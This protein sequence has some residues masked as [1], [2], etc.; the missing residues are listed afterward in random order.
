MTP[1]PREIRSYLT[2]ES[3]HRLLVAALSELGAELEDVRAHLVYQISH[4]SVT[5]QAR[6]DGKPGY[7]VATTRPLPEHT[8]T[9]G[10]EQAAQR[11][12][13]VE[14]DIGPVTVFVYPHDPFL[15]ALASLQAEVPTPADVLAYRPT[16]R[17]VLDLG[18]RGFAKIAAPR[19]TAQL[20]RRHKQLSAA[21][22]PVPRV[23]E[24]HP[25]AVIISRLQGARLTAMVQEEG[26]ASTYAHVKALLDSLPAAV[27]R[28]PARRSWCER[29]E[30]H[31][32]SARTV[33][34]GH[35]QRIERIAAAV[36]EDLDAGPPGPIVPTHGDLYE[37]N[38]LTEQGRITGLL[39]IDGVGP[40][41]R[42]DDLAC[43]LGHLSVIPLASYSP[44]F[45]WAITELWAEAAADL[46]PER[47][48]V[49]AGGIALTLVAG[50]MRDES[51]PYE[52][53]YRAA[54]HRLQIAE[55]WSRGA[56]PARWLSPM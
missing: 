5:Y 11:W 48:A 23:L 21:G 26:G 17:A 22:L 36:A 25:G 43:L 28:L 34:P 8:T 47:L 7:L 37:A 35:A 49:R 9:H 50:A 39:D 19:A 41:Y 15:P 52:A 14:S 46:D 27:T 33:L 24:E 51:R 1:H 53:R 38:V 42:I 4:T 44:E 56:P 40:G 32:R 54:V 6:L 18:E 13:T 12:V 16:R 29:I 45:G 55:A 30:R 3:S 20:A 2:G 31:A 10:R